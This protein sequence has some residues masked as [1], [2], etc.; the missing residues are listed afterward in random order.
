M[1]ILSFPSFAN[2]PSSLGKPRSW[3]LILV[4]A[5]TLAACGGEPEP[6][7]ALDE[8]PSELRAGNWNRVRS[9]VPLTPEQLEQAN[10]LTALGYADGVQEAPEIVQVT[11][12]D[13]ARAQQGLNFYVSGQAPEAFLIDMQG[14][15]QHHWSHD[16]ALL[17]PQL[18]IRPNASGIG[19]W[20]R[21]HLYPNGDILAIHEGI[22]MIRL[23]ADSKL[24]WQ[25]PGRTHHD[26]H[27]TEEGHIWT[28]AREVGIHPVFSD[29]RVSMD[30]LLVELDKDGNQLRRL[31]ILECLQNV[32]SELLQKI[33]FPDM[34]HANS[35]EVLDARLEGQAA[36]FE[37]GNILV[38]LRHLHALVVIDVEAEEVVWSLEGDFRWQHDAQ[39]TESGSLLLFDN[40][41]LPEAAPI[42]KI[43]EFDPATG[44]LLWSFEGSSREPFYSKTCGTTQRLGN[45]NTLIT[46]SDGGRAFEITPQGEVVWEYYNPHRGGPGNE[47]IACLF[48]LHR[49]GP[50]AGFDWLQGPARSEE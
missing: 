30:D 14:Q 22:G 43:L 23:N 44:E 24:L 37:A 38:S 34:F 49:I 42:S 6:V 15:V 1:R 45:Q 47:F 29:E 10:D 25:Y 8:V 40:H 33:E 31:S 4:I 46:E 27:V 12:Y 26:M 9:Q 21:A 39:I 50:Q 32:D 28:L 20:R 36:G 16:Y 48:A 35:I 7:P 17:W 19:K 2:Q 41:R 11:R 13:P 18:K 5:S 3:I